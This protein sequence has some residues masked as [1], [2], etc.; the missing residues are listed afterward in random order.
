[1]SN[2][3]TFMEK[4]DIW[5]KLKAL[6]SISIPY[7]GSYFSNKIVLFWTLCFFYN[8]NNP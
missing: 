7:Q 1:M 2:K 5:D 3:D 6:S 4:K 8:M